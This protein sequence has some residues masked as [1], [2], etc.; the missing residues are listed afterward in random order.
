MLGVAPGGDGVVEPIAGDRVQFG[1]VD[2]AAALTPGVEAHA[3]DGGAGCVGD[4][5]Q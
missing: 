4:H 1:P 2:A 5:I 3:L